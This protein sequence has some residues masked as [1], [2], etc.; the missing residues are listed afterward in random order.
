MTPRGLFAAAC[1]LSLQLGSGS[2]QAWAEKIIDKW[3]TSCTGGLTCSLRYEDFHE[4]FGEFEIRRTGALGSDVT[5]RLPQP[6]GF[7]RTLDPAGAFRLDVDGK[8]VMRVPLQ[9][10]TFDAEEGDFVLAD[11]ASVQVLL[12]AMKTGT[13]L[14]VSYEGRT[15]KFSK[16]M[17][18]A[19]LRGSLFFIDDIQGRRGRNDALFAVGTKVPEGPDSKDIVSLDDI[20]ASIRADFTVANGACTEGFIPEDIKRYNG[21]DISISGTRLVLVPCGGGGAYNQPYALYRGYYTGVLSRVSFPDV[22]EG[23]PSVSEVEYNVDFDPATRIMTAYLK[24]SGITACGR[25][26]KWEL[27]LDGYL[28]LLEKRSWEECDGSHEGPE[29]FPM[30]WPVKE[31][32]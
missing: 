17:N 15:G 32:Q 12:E 29:T 6:P 4:D 22:A 28:V 20:P 25:W 30:D 23:K 24:D 2:A 3:S 14:R 19:G 1:L 18:L 31:Q 21:F 9:Q 16:D 13:G 26:S 10:L 27:T 5:L 7:D 8:E 11:K